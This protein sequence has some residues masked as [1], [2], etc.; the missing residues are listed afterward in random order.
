MLRTPKRMMTA[1]LVI[2][3]LSSE[4]SLAQ[5]PKFLRLEEA[6]ELCLQN[7]KQLKLNKVKIEAATASTVEARER[8][9]PDLSGS[10][11]YVRLTRPK[12]GGPLG[13]TSSPDIDEAAYAIV[14][15]SIPLFTG[16]RTKNGIASAKYLEEA[17]RLDAENDKDAVVQNAVAAYSN[18]YKA[19]TSVAIIKENLKQA[20]Q[21]SA[22]FANMERNGLIARNDLLRVQL[23]QSNIELALLDAESNQRLANLH[24]NIML[25]LDETTVL[26]LDS[27]SFVD[28]EDSRTFSEFEQIAL[29]NRHDLEALKYREQSAFSGIKIAKADYYPNLRVTAGYFAANIPDLFTISNAWNAGLGLTYNVASIWKTGA[30]VKSAK[31]RLAEIKATQDIMNDRVKLEVAQA[32]EGYVLSKKKIEVYAKAVEQASENNR[33]TKNKYRNNLVTTT[34]LL[35]AFVQELL[36]NLDY[37]HSKADAAVAY[38]K[39]LQTS[40]IAT[41]EPKK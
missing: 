24:M 28:V 20:E 39:L 1:I 34:D 32:F 15:G 38:R 14:N 29:S 21:R 12:I 19:Q 35:D 36:A 26:Q 6:I 25:G 13:N 31:I 8:R 23:Q 22:D 11:N 10:A 37:A 18:L 7:N 5:S 2:A 4:V 30:K 16:F 41:S 40:G 27:T 9:L 3:G 33:I 17:T